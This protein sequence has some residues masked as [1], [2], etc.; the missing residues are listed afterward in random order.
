MNCAEWDRQL[1]A[2]LTGALPERDALEFE[3][4]A[5]ECAA[6]GE[7]LDQLSRVSGVP[8]DIAPPGT[9]RSATMRAVAA[10]RPAARI[11]RTLGALAGIA[12]VALLAMLLR[13]ARKSASDFPG[14]GQVLMAMEHAR[15]EFAEL[16]AAERDLVRA[17]SDR[18][19]D[20]ELASSLARVR[21]QREALR[22]LVQQAR[23]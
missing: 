19:E 9:L 6:C 4:H 12:A 2:W 13:P 15:P 18:P 17:L 21:R 11:R 7:R 22:E 23:S 16:D 1:E 20:P 3:R 5:A 10:R 8:R 14:A